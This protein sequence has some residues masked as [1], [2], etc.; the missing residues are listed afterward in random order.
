M[1]GYETDFMKL[2]AA[3]ASDNGCETLGL[4]G[5]AACPNFA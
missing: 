3:A 2:E 4:I 5:S 1:D